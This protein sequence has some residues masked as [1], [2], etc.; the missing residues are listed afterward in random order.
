MKLLG[1]CFTAGPCTRQSNAI[2]TNQAGIRA[3]PEIAVRRLAMESTFD[4]KKPSRMVQALCA[5]WLTSSAG[6]KAKAAGPASASASVTA[7]VH[8]CGRPS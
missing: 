4:L 5:Y 6:F 2:E 3:D 1:R 7:I 8:G